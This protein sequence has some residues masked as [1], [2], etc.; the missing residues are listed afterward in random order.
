MPNRYL[1]TPTCDYWSF[2]AEENTARYPFKKLDS[3]IARGWCTSLR[4]STIDTTDECRRR[5]K[6]MAGLEPRP[7]GLFC[8]TTTLHRVQILPARDISEKSSKIQV[9]KKLQRIFFSFA[10]AEGQTWD[11]LV[12][13]LFSLSSSALDHSATAPPSFK[14]MYLNFVF[15]KTFLGFWS[16]VATFHLRSRKN[17]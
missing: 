12:F 14:E 8:W 6:K 7:I 15:F 9:R 16:R 11:L 13:R 17:Y 5:M 4:Y 1:I 10:Q 2:F 3:Y